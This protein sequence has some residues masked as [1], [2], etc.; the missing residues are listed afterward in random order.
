LAFA[1][2]SFG[3]Y[4]LALAALE[5]AVFGAYDSYPLKTIHSLLFVMTVYREKWGGKVYLKISFK[6]RTHK[7]V[8]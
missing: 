2:F 7:L 4:G 5:L 1:T 3:G 6:K 8:S